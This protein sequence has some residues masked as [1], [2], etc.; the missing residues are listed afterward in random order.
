MASLQGPRRRL[1]VGWTPHAPEEKVLHVGK[2]GGDDAHV[3]KKRRR[4]GI[5]RITR[6]RKGAHG[7]LAN[8]A[9]RE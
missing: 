8:H 2:R 6:E 1:G 3:G 7:N 4:A 9:G 5:L